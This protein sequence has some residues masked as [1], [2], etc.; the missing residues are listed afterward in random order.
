MKQIRDRSNYR[1]LQGAIVVGAVSLAVWRYHLLDGAIPTSSS[2]EGGDFLTY[3]RAAQHVSVG[4]SPYQLSP[5]T[6]GH[7][8]GYVYSPFVAVALAPLA[9]ISVAALWKLWIA[10]SI[11]VLLTGAGLFAYDVSPVLA[12]WKRPLVLGVAALTSLKFMPTEVTLW[13]GNADALIFLLLVVTTLAIRRERAFETGIL[14][15]IGVLIKSWP[16]LVI[17]VVLNQGFSKRSRIFAGFLSATLAGTL[18][19]LPIGGL[20]TL[21]SWMLVTL[22][23]SSQPFISC[24]VW[25]APKLLFGL[26]GEA[27]PLIVSI[28]LQFALTVILASFVIGLL[29]LVIRRS[30][31]RSVTFWHVVA[32][33]ILLLPVSHASYTLFLLPIMWTWISKFIA[34]PFE[35]RVVTVLASASVLW[36]LSLLPTALWRGPTSVSS[37]IYEVPF[38][39]NL[40]LVAISIIG[41]SRLEIRSKVS[42]LVQ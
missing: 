10:F 34:A 38:I 28:Q 5:S 25:G 42:T 22:H 27:K 24:S 37:L 6:D 14:I 20:A 7:D 36:W 8:F 19:F 9:S 30:R 12:R 3:L 2:G 4:S 26:S 40:A 41:E 11:A 13:W 16:G 39:A 23:S 17:L 21:R 31:N 29:V 18:L 32:C 15:G 33:I 1:L 35:S